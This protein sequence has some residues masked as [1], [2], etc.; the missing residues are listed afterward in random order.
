MT[1]VYI[2]DF[3]IYDCK[4][5]G[6]DSLPGRLKPLLK[7]PLVYPALEAQKN[8]GNGYERF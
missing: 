8:Q 7:M 6:K 1:I 5:A 4:G 2:V 3:C